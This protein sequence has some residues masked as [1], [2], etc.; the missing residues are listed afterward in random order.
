[1]SSYGAEISGIAFGPGYQDEYVVSSR[2]QAGM[3]ARFDG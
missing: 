1:M 2:Q 3:S